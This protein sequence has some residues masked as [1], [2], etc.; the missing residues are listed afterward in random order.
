MSERITLSKRDINKPLIEVDFRDEKI[1]MAVLRDRQVCS[2]TVKKINFFGTNNSDEFF[3]TDENGERH[4]IF[5]TWAIPIIPFIENGNSEDLVNMM[6]NTHNFL[7]SLNSSSKLKSS[8]ENWTKLNSEQPARFFQS[9]ERW[10]VFA[11]I[12]DQRLTEHFQNSPLPEEHVEKAAELFLRLMVSF[13][14]SAPFY[15]LEAIVGDVHNTYFN[16]TNRYP[17]TNPTGGSLDVVGMLLP[18]ALPNLVT[19]K[20]LDWNN[21]TWEKIKNSLK[22]SSYDERQI[23][24]RIAKEIDVSPEDVIFAANALEFIPV[25]VGG[26]KGDVSLEDAQRMI[27]ESLDRNRITSTNSVARNTN[28]LIRFLNWFPVV[29]NSD[30]FKGLGWRYAAV[31]DTSSQLVDLVQKS[32]LL[33]INYSDIFLNTISPQIAHVDATSAKG[34]FMLQLLLEDKFKQ[35]VYNQIKSRH[36]SFNNEINKVLSEKKSESYIVDIHDY[37]PRALVGGKSAGLREASLIFGM[38][39]VIPG[40]TIT[41][42]AINDMLKSDNVLWG[43]ILELNSTQNIDKRMEI[44]KSI[45]ESILNIELPITASFYNNKIAVRS[46]S[47]DEDSDITGSAAGIYESVICENTDD[48]PNCVTKVVSSFFSEKAVSFR[49]LHGLSDIPMFAIILCTF[50][51]GSGGIAFS[52]GN[53][54]GWEV[55]TSSS[56]SKIA[57]NHDSAFDSFKMSSTGFTKKVNKNWVDE[58]SVL[59]VG[60]MAK[61]AEQYLGQR[62]DI[63]FVVDKNN[64]LWVLQLRTLRD[65]KIKNIDKSS[66]KVSKISINSLEELSELKVSNIDKHNLVIGRNIDLNQ[67]QGTLFRWLVK[68]RDTIKTITLA[69]RIPRTGHFANICLQL[70]IDLKFIND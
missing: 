70:G 11:L 31:C 57:D 55:V 53:G 17:E 2:G 3:V 62:V 32:D 34:R 37:N 18:S 51:E 22:T 54:N 14:L 50:I 20:K 67:F 8:F 65:N 25:N 28:A 47:F 66:I 15:N 7:D 30:N 21:L 52:S 63:E 24:F 29:K 64:K 35:E 16:P 49:T 60:E 4:G 39:N 19:S 40:Q 5:K 56:P 59:M 68:N 13:E 45:Q 10:R 41:S 27:I 42:E 36:A 26:K 33:K 23:V 12:N 6:S 38:D 58:K 1:E 9:M 46:S 69:T 43:K 48:L 61:K 44:S